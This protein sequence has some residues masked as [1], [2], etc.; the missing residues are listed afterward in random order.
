M[1]VSPALT[2]AVV[3]GFV[4]LVVL[5]VM[6]K[7]ARWTRWEAVLEHVAKTFAGRY[8]TGFKKG[9]VMQPGQVRATIEG[10][11]LSLEIVTRSRYGSDVETR[12]VV[13][14]IGSGASEPAY[15]GP[16]RQTPP[17]QLQDYSKPGQVAER[18]DLQDG[19]AALEGLGVSAGLR[20]A[21]TE[22]AGLRE[23]IRRLIVDG[24]RIAHG[25][26]IVE[27]R[28]VEYDGEVMVRRIHE[29]VALGS[30]VARHQ[31]RR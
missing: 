14:E 19:G 23:R 2:V 16:V 25:T 12:F 4:V 26:V 10:R 11:D 6:R 15:L 3:A 20:A 31:Q 7:R 27:T 28:H 1:P 8:Q 24:G 17:T 21:L 9:L 29:L 13:L 18:I 5:L 30:E 22:D